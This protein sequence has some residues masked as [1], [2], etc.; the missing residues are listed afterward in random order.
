MIVPCEWYNREPKQVEQI[1]I[2]QRTQMEMQ[3]DIHSL[4]SPDKHTGQ[5]QQ[6]TFSASGYH[7]V[8]S[9]TLE[10]MRSGNALHSA[11]NK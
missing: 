6:M 5:Q 4:F 8:C 7:R 10:L 1:Q 3:I 11:K 2:D 9:P